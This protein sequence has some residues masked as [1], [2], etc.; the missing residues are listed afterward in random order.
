MCVINIDIDINNKAH[1]GTGKASLK[2]ESSYNE[3]I[4]QLQ[5]SSRVCNWRSLSNGHA[6]AADG[7]Y[8]PIF[9][10]VCGED[11]TF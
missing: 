8:K 1:L 6:T 4:P 10:I 2:E 3:G 11:L 5:K 9:V 7:P